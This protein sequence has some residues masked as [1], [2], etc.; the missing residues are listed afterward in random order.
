LVLANPIFHAG[1][2][3]T[4]AKLQ[5]LPQQQQPNPECI[6][7]NASSSESIA[8]KIAVKKRVR[9]MGRSNVNVVGERKRKK[10]E[11]E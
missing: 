1:H 7:Q 6:P 10:R 8:V 11:D 4:G 3:A 5:I 9:L 2:T